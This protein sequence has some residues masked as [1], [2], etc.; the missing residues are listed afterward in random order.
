MKKNLIIL[1]TIGLLTFI[2]YT[3]ADV[4]PNRADHEVEKCVRIWE[5]NQTPE[6]KERNLY[7]ETTHITKGWEKEKHKIIYDTCLKK[8]PGYKYDAYTLLLDI[9]N[10]GTYTLTTPQTEAY[11]V[12]KDDPTIYHEEIYVIDQEK[13][14]YTLKKIYEIKKDQNGKEMTFQD[15]RIK[16]ENSYFDDVKKGHP[17]FDAIKELKKKGII[18][19][20]NQTSYAPEK[21]I[22]RGEFLK[23]L[24]WAKYKKDYIEACKPRHSFFDENDKNFDTYKTYICVAANNGIIKGFPD[25]TFRVNQ[26]I[27]F[28]QATKIALLSLTSNSFKEEKTRY[29]EYIESLNKLSAVPVTLINKTPNTLINRWE[30]AQLVMNLIKEK[31]K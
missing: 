31:S 13:D 11:F 27:N 9:P 24:I 4:A 28:A 2:T 18:K 22:S 5:N 15:E 19:G 17:Y 21:L 25:W 12:N 10:K 1:A 29:Q 7:G 30:T 3:S 23:I 16:W 14:E 26:K 8:H 20:Y 6:Q